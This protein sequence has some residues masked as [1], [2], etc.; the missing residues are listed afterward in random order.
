M[1]EFFQDQEKTALLFDAQRALGTKLVFEAQFDVAAAKHSV[2]K[3]P[4]FFHEVDGTVVVGVNRPDHPAQRLDHFLRVVQDFFQDGQYL[5]RVFGV[6]H[7]GQLGQEIDVAEG[8]AHVVVQVGGNFVADFLQPKLAAQPVDAD[9][10]QHHAQQQQAVGHE[11]RNKPIFLPKSLFQMKFQRRHPVGVVQV[12]DLKL[13]IAAKKVDVGHRLAPAV[14]APVALQSQ[15][16]T[17]V[18]RPRR[19]AWVAE[20]NHDMRL[21]VVQ[22]NGLPQVVGRVAKFVGGQ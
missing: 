8:A 7:P 12:L 3:G 10:V 11:H 19:V 20:I 22:H 21:A 5:R 15:Q 1:D 2:S 9:K 17:S 18:G 13:V 4:D 14:G 6:L 16:A